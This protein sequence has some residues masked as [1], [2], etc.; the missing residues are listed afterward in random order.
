M[1]K[2]FLLSYLGFNSFEFSETLKYFFINLKFSI[3]ERF[4]K[5]LL[6]AGCQRFAERC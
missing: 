1:L 6:R 2:E 5:T 3:Y 4:K